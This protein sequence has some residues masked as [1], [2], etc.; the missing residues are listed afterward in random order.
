MKCPIEKG[1][2]TIVQSVELPAEIPKGRLINI[3]SLVEGEANLCLNCV[4]LTAKFTVNAQAWTQPPEYPMG[5]ATIVID[6]M[7]RN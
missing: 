2:H 3:Y 1:E 6:F 7:D 5:C 4:I